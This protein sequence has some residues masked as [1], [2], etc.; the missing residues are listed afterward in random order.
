M[1]EILGFDSLFAEMILGIGVALI[2]GNA[3]AYRQYRKGVRPE[4]IEADAPFNTGRVIWL[5]VIGVL[6]SAWGGLSVFT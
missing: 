2:L 5:S 4:G 1:F 6:M 3:W